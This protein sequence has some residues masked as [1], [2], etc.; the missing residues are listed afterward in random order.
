MG[1]PTFEEAELAYLKQS[2]IYH[3]RYSF[4]RADGPNS[5]PLYSWLALQ[6]A[7]DQEILTGA[8]R[9]YAPSAS[10]YAV[11]RR[12]IFVIQWGT[13]RVNTIL[14]QLYARTASA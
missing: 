6:A 7:E 13:G 12:A 10:A 1:T 14:S 2:F 8:A 5:S 9:E 4:G 3:G 11:R